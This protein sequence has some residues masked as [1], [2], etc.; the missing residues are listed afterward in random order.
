MAYCS[1]ADVAAHDYQWTD[2]GSFTTTTEPTTAQVGAWCDQ[3]SAMFDTALSNSGFTVPIVQATVLLDLK[4]QTS[5]IVSDVV[6]ARHKTGRFFTDK[7]LERGLS[8]Q[9][10]ARQE[11]E[12]WVKD[13]AA[14][15]QNLGVPRVLSDGLGAF[16]VAA[17]R[18]M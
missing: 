4:L 13:N 17:A 11:A 8:W 3:V 18:Q 16:S 1:A 14:G 15:L 12:Q 5:L 9:I 10:L 2:N 7:V 6:S